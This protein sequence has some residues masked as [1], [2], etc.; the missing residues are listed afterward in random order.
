MKKPLRLVACALLSV[1]APPLAAAAPPSVRQTDAPRADA[2]QNDAAQPD[3]PQP[4]AA[5]PLTPEARRAAARCLKLT[6]AC[7]LND[8]AIVQVAHAGPQAPVL[9]VPYFGHYVALAWL[10]H[11]QHTQ[12]VGSLAAAEKWL[13]WCASHQEQDGYWNH[14]EGTRSQYKSLKDCDAW[15]S[16]AALYLLVLD[17]FTAAGG[18]ASPDMLT[19]AQKSLACLERLVDESGLTIAKPDSP[20]LFLMDNV[21]SAAGARGATELFARLDRLEEKQRAEKLHARLAR[22]LPSYWDPDQ[23]VYAWARHPSGKADVRLTKA[24]PDALAQLFAVAHLSPNADLFDML[25]ARF[26]PDA[27]PMAAVGVERWAMAASELGGDRADAW[28]GKLI[29]E[30]NQFG[31]DVYSYRPAVALLALLDGGGVLKP[32]T[33][34]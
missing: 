16:S 4:E 21:E 31:P 11:H 3:V 10:A 7:Q 15:D 17:R 12:D 33:Q 8:G 32:Q 6:L 26:E 5:R 34:P 29:H 22:A 28:R 23:S 14:W 1:A 25:A 9:I 18:K 19:A 27:G 20:V 30:I 13:R 24:Y 2:L